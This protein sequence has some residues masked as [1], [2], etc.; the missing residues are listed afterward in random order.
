[1]TFSFKCFCNVFQ[2]FRNI[3]LLRTFLNAAFTFAAV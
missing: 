3:Y 1:M 2:D